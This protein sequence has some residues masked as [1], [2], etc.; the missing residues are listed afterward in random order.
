MRWGIELWDGFDDVSNYLHKGIE[1]FEKYEE[2]WKKR[3]AIENQ[4]AKSLRKLVES[5]EPKSRKDSEESKATHV[6]CFTRMLSELKDIAGQHELIA[7]NVQDKVIQ[8]LIQMIKTLKEDR[9]KCIE[10]QDR[11]LNEHQSSDDLLEKCKQRYEKAFKEVEKAKEQLIKVENDDSAS[12]ND[13]KKQ[14]SVVDSKQTTFNQ[15]QAEYGNQLCEANRAKA[16]Y[17]NE[18]LPSIMDSLHSMEVKR[19]ESFKQFVL[20]AVSIEI[21]VVPR[22]QQCLREIES[23]ASQISSDEDTEIVVSLF[24]TGY[25]IPPDH[26][27]DDLNEKFNG[28]M[29]NSKVSLNTSINK[30]GS[31]TNSSTSSTTTLTNQ[32]SLNALNGNGSSNPSLSPLLNNRHH[33]ISNGGSNNNS[34]QKKYRTI[35]RIKGL[36]FTTTA[37]TMNHGAGH[38]GG[39]GSSSS[40][41]NGADFD[42]NLFDLPPQQMKKEVNKRIETISNEI[43]TKQKEREGLNKLKDIYSSNQKFGDSQSALEAL[44]VNEEKLTLLNSQ[45]KKYQE[46][47]SELE[48]NGYY[49]SQQQQQQQSHYAEYD[50]TSQNKLNNI[51]QSSTSEH[52]LNSNGNS[53]PGTPMSYHNSIAKCSTLGAYAISSI[54]QMNPNHKIIN[55]SSMTTNGATTNHNKNGTNN[56]TDGNRQAPIATNDRSGSFEDEEDEEEE[57]DDYEKENNSNNFYEKPSS[58]IIHQSN[59][60]VNKSHGLTTN[61]TSTSSS[62][63][64]ATSTQLTK[65]NYAIS[66]SS[67]QDTSTTKY[68]HVDST[69]INSSQ[70]KEQQIINNYND[71]DDDNDDDLIIGTALVI[72]AFSGTVQNAMSVEENEALNVLEKDSGDGWTL[73]KRLNGEKG[74]VPT[75]YIRIV[76]Y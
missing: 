47:L 4:Y 31:T 74:Y 3:C 33:P 38:N 35:N 37:L 19:V 46:I 65:I 28:L 52:S 66:S 56:N 69:T 7:E 26:V 71:N 76:Y 9:R 44:K 24:K 32:R 49:S 30:N 50:Q 16:V 70:N 42:S 53:L 43:N 45:L 51:Y 34:R 6:K 73:V 10:D 64:S 72:Y 21:E 11:C 36:L 60:N 58:L 17:Y 14:K 59:S 25:S 61:G 67:Y 20:D 55:T 8:R 75:D 41:K 1:F 39:S 23:S 22:I 57:D 12:K 27:F 15:C 62:S 54:S 48:V 29:N 18:K 13:I 68:D 63:S 5:Y 2:F 40:H